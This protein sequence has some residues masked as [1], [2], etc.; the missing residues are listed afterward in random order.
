MI[1][2][3]KFVELLVWLICTVLIFSLTFFVLKLCFGCCDFWLDF[4]VIW[5]V[6]FLV[7]MDG[8]SLL[9]SFHFLVAMLCRLR[10]YLF[11]LRASWRRNLELACGFLHVCLLC[12]G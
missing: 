12:Y 3:I 5:K 9:V 1:S 2:V 8:V 6:H 11:I 10:G 7:W 4:L